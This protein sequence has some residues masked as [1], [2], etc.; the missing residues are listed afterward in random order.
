MHKRATERTR[1]RTGHD[2]RS[3][4]AAD[5]L[6]EIGTEELPA[7][8]LPGLI[9][10][11]GTKAKSMLKLHHL[12]CQRVESFGTP[13]RLVLIVRGLHPIQRAPSR[14]IRGPAKAAS[15]DKDGKPTSA[16][17]GFLRSRGGKLSQTKIVSSDKGE[18]VYLIKPPTERKT[19]EVLGNPLLGD[20]LGQLIDQLQAPKTMRWDTSG[21]RFARPIRRLLALYGS[22]PVEVR[23]IGITYAPK[24]ARGQMILKSG[25]FTRVGRPQ[26]LRHVRVASIPGYVQTLKRA[27]IILDQDERRRCIQQMVEREAKRVGGIV[28]PEMMSHGLLDEVTHLVEQ[29]VALAGQFD[30]KYLALPRE[31]LLASMAKY[32]RVFAIEARKSSTARRLDGSRQETLLPRFVAILEGPPRK[33][34]AVRQII[35]RI[36]NARLADSLMFWNEDHKR[37]PLEQ[38]AAALSG[39]TFHERIGSMADKAERVHTLSAVL[40]KAWQLSREELKDLRRACQLAKADLVSTLVKEFPTLQGVIGKYYARH[41]REPQ[42]VAEAIEEHYLPIG[43]R[44]PK[45]LIGSALAILDKYDTLA[46][47]FAQG[48][49][50]TGDQDPFGLRRAAQ[51]IIE[52]AWAVHRPLPIERLLEAR[53]AM[54]PFSEGHQDPATHVGNVRQRLRQYLAER[55]Y[56]FS[57]PAPAPSHDLIEA[58]LSSP[59]DDLVDAMHRMVSLRQLDG[60]PTLLKAAKVVERTHN[61]LKSATVRQTSVEPARFQEPLE[62]TLWD[63]HQTCKD[64]LFALVQSK[65]YADAT[66]LYGEVFFGPL[67]EFFER[68]LVNVND[69]AIQ[70]NRLALM[71]TINTLYTEHIADLSKLTIL[72]QPRE[73]SPR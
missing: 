20:P 55:L 50:P 11:L 54:P 19:T 64:R 52:V 31:V 15:Y 47:Y 38:M 66:T 58:V 6:L 22:T 32:Q 51:G 13:R 25:R 72:Q 65:S 14:E 3:A 27:G 35:E 49:L 18:H 68:V 56:T 23:L 46:S 33:L 44:L 40:E 36:L 39:V 61:I 7:A 24:E 9:E 30:S 2:A 8:Y 29:P 1:S 37:L 10:Q 70:Q 53:A 71:K 67:H 63:L 62:H 34:A 59:W 48:I 45:T 4:R 5:L 43:D 57:W 60:K 28:S 26:A 12:E 41:S 16:L 17:L 21:V 73:E 42:E 69:E